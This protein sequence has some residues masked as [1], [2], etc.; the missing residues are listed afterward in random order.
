M[1]APSRT[2]VMIGWIVGAAVGVALIEWILLRHEQPRPSTGELVFAGAL[3]VVMP[4]LV[5]IIRRRYA[6]RRP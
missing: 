5:R 1:T 4:I 2:R 6:R 3:V